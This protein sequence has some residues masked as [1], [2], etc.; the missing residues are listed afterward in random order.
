VKNVGALLEN[1]NALNVDLKVLKRGV[2]RMGLMRVIYKIMPSEPGEAIINSILSDIKSLSQNMGIKLHDSK[3]EPIAFGLYSLK[4][5]ISLPEEDDKLLNQ[6][7]SRLK[8]V[9]GVESIEVVGM[10]RA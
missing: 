9:N 1:T 10:T 8:E 5:L 7:E 2:Y 3:T 4:I 6:F